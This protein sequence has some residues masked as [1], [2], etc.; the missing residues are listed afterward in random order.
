MRCGVLTV[1]PTKNTSCLL[2]SCFF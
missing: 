2:R 1:T